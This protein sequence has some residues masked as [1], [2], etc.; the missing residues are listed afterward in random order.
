M[1]RYLKGLKSRKLTVDKAK[2]R[3]AEKLDGNLC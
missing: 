2:V 3:K 1:G